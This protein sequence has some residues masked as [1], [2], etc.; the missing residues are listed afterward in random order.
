M[1]V[2]EQFSRFKGHRGSK[3][4]EA[5]DLCYDA[6]ETPSANKRKQLARRALKLFPDCADAYVILA[7]DSVQNLERQKILWTKAVQ[8]GE[9]ALGPDAMKENKGYFW[10]VVET[11]SYMRARQGLSQ[12]LW[13]LG[14]AGE[15]ID[16]AEEMLVLNPHDN[17]GVR[18]YL[19]AW[20]VEQ[21]IEGFDREREI[22][23]LTGKYPEEGWC[24]WQYT[25]ALWLF[26]KGRRKEAEEYLCEGSQPNPHV[27]DYLCGV[28]AL[29]DEMPFQST[30]GGV[31]EAIIYVHMYGHLWLHVP[32]A[33]D[34]LTSIMLTQALK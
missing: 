27:A 11:R 20:L 7:Q 5:Q 1:S 21:D 25:L 26:F 12:C 9:R 34:W 17:Q 24:D 10:G 18:Y 33:V 32:E 14:E 13:E 23:Q 2:I 16:H 8:A 29:P 28:E 22:E 30:Y 15:A 6:W 19:L 31:D 3:E 4:A